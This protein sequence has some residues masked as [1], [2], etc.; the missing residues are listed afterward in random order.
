MILWPLAALATST[1]GYDQEVVWPR[2][3]DVVGT[4]AVIYAVDLEPDQ[5][6]PLLYLDGVEVPATTYLLDGVDGKTWRVS[7][8]NAPLAP[9][10]YVATAGSYDQVSFTVDEAQSPVASVPGPYTRVRGDCPGARVLRLR[11]CGDAILFLVAV[12]DVEPASPSLDDLGTAWVGNALTTWFDVPVD[13]FPLTVWVG[14]LD[15]AGRFTGWWPGD[16]VTSPGGQ[17]VQEAPAGSDA[18]AH[19]SPAR[20]TCTGDGPWERLEGDVC[21]AV[22]D[23]DG[24]PSAEASTGCGCASG[25]PGA[26][27]ILFLGLFGI[28]RRLR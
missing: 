9:G 3:D 6:D 4:D 23:D 10:A 24:A 16:T 21:E 22:A 25:G 26:S 27:W 28:R 7:V 14:G 18:S 11:P 8:P 19:V 17:V 13:D 20:A 15:E 1:P 12:G 2:N 5:V